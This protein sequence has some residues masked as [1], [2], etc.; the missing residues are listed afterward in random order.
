MNA[1][2]HCE[3][4]MRPLFGQEAQPMADGKLLH[5]ACRREEQPAP[6]CGTREHQGS[7]VL[8]TSNKEQA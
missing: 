2:P 7:L 4:C 3:Y 6:K 5:W 8:P 1:A